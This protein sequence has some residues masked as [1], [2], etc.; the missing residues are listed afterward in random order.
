MRAIFTDTILRA[1][2]V[3]PE[4]KADIQNTAAGAGSRVAIAL[5]ALASAAILVLAIVAQA[6]IGER[7]NGDMRA[8]LRLNVGQATAT[9]SARLALLNERLRVIPNPSTA[10]FALEL[11]SH[12]LLR[13]LDEGPD[14]LVESVVPTSDTS[15]RVPKANYSQGVL[16]IMFPA[17]DA[18][19]PAIDAAMR[20]D[21]LERAL[22]PT[23]FTDRAV[24][25]LAPGGEVAAIAGPAGSLG[26][27]LGE[28]LPLPVLSEAALSLSSHHVSVW[29]RKNGTLLIASQALEPGLLVMIVTP[30]PAAWGATAPLIGIL[31]IVLMVFGGF[32][33]LHRRQ[34]LYEQQLVAHAR[35]SETLS[36]IISECPGCGLLDWDVDGGRIYWSASLMSLVGRPAR[37]VWLSLPET[38]Q[39]LHPTEVPKLERVRHLFEDGAQLYAGLMR[40]Q[41]L[42]GRTIWCQARLRPWQNSRERIVGLLVDITEQVEE[43]LEAQG[44]AQH[45]K[46]LTTANEGKDTIGLSSEGSIALRQMLDELEGKRAELAQKYFSEKTRAED[47]YRAKSEFLAN[48]SHELK[49]PLNAIIGFAEIMQDELYG[50]IGDERYRAYARGIQES[51]RA[52]TQLIDEILEMSKI[53]AGNVSL[54]IEELDIAALAS[55]CVRLAEPRA[56]E[57]SVQIDNRINGASKAYG[58]RRATKRIVLNLLSNAVKFTHR[59]GDVTLTTT[60]DDDFVTISVADTGIGIS[61][62]DLARLGR[63]FEQVEKH[64]SRRHRGPGLGLAIAFALSEMQGGAL[65]IESSEGV[66][67]VVSV[68]VPRRNAERSETDERLLQAG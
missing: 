8:Q 59:G 25:V 6:K 36:D 48:M 33:F 26:V 68:T 42:G 18:R 44:T 17:L 38:Y 56:R 22:A 20:I 29:T 27:K 47:A 5:L 23:R 9:L 16:W 31:A 15:A 67:T 40:L 55:E 34:K 2:A 4:K 21:W 39:L 19:R 35:A 30:S 64:H 50:A 52:L 53:E 41:S 65:K 12:S 51:G 45:L 24:L 61:Q 60:F 37:G 11:K 3:G 66:G 49:T 7:E 57:S 62:N 1:R 32:A 28:R 46:G 54:E 43:R 10:G 13:R 63:P 58:D 14:P